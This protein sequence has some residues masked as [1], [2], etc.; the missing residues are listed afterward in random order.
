M[1]QQF[2]WIER[3][4]T[5]PDQVVPSLFFFFFF[6][7]QQIFVLLAICLHSRRPLYIIQNN[8]RSRM[9]TILSLLRV[10]IPE[11]SF[12]FRNIPTC[13]LIE[14]VDVQPRIPDCMQCWTRFSA[15]KLEKGKIHQS[16]SNPL[17]FG[18]HV[19]FRR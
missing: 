17:K 11:H 8:G 3:Y 4:P 13:L 12:Y 19:P 10:N 18:Y 6:L 16:E 5:N 7:A 15:Q 1:L 14:L 2:N 9:A